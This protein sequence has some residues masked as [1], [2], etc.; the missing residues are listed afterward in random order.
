MN[1]KEERMQILRMIQNGQISA[2]EGA[3]LIAAL[4]SSKKSEATANVAATQGKFLRVRVTD[5]N[6]GRA[7]VNVNL[8]LALV[9][10]GL[11]MGARFVPD[12]AGMDTGEIMEAIRSGLVGKIVEVED[13]EDGEKVEVFIE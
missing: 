5:M 1:M 11:K 13:G 2:E 7:K 10:V 4:D 6:T 8:P 9:T 12:L 3:K